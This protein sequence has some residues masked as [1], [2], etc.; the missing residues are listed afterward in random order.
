MTNAEK[1]IKEALLEYYSDTNKIYA[2]LKYLRNSL[3]GIDTAAD[4]KNS[5]VEDILIY[6]MIYGWVNQE[7]NRKQLAYKSSHEGI[8]NSTFYIDYS[9]MTT[10]ETTLDRAINALHIY[11]VPEDKIEDTKLKLMMLGD[12]EVKEQMI[13]KTVTT[14]SSTNTLSILTSNLILGFN[15]LGDYVQL[16]RWLKDLDEV[17][18]ITDNKIDIIKELEENQENSAYKALH[19]KI[20]AAIDN[21]QH[22]NELLT[23]WKEDA[24]QEEKRHKD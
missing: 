9:R 2:E 17:K 10:I 15:Y 24:E 23:Q 8:D 16:I 11:E 12:I 1:E 20:W 3:P 13:T 19:R 21:R 22:I 6:N 5:A 18:V 14:F 4:L 7:N